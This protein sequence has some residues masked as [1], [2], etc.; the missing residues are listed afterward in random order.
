MRK[1]ILVFISVFVIGSIYGQSPELIS[2]Q[3][4]IRN[5]NNAL[6]SN[7]DVGIQITIL[8]GSTGGTAVYV[9]EHSARTNA[10]GLVTVQ[11]GGGTPTTGFFPSIDWI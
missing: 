4:V 10:N 1:I 3:A 7:Q 6:V 11:I 9:E 2:Y 8:Q 5:N